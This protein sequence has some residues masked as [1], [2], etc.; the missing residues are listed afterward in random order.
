MSLKQKIKKVQGNVLLLNILFIAWLIPGNAAM[1]PIFII[2][3]TFIF[4]VF[5]VIHLEKT[6]INPLH[7]VHRLLAER[8]IMMLNLTNEEKHYL[9]IDLGDA[10]NESQKIYLMLMTIKESAQDWPDDKS[11]RWLGYCQYFMINNGYTT[12]KNEREYSRPMFH[13]AYA[14]MGIRKPESVQIN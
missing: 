14:K 4:E 7:R 9:N 8:Y 12:V 5:Y 6:H 3:L 11:S 2:G 10:K 13:D 1:V